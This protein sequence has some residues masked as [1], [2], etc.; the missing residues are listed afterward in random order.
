M[1]HFILFSFTSNSRLSIV[2]LFICLSV[3]NGIFIKS[4]REKDF[5]STFIIDQPDSS[6]AHYFATLSCFSVKKNSNISISFEM[7]NEIIT[8]QCPSHYFSWLYKKF[9]AFGFTLS[10]LCF[11]K[12][13]ILKIFF[14]KRINRAHVQFLF[15]LY[16]NIR[17]CI[18]Y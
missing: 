14:F 7:K 15:V 18:E 16:W 8:V 9:F 10:H 12:L 13:L 1:L 5:Q 6:S 4:D 11:C 2:C 17:N 3:C